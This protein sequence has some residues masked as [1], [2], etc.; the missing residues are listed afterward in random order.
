M[1][2]LHFGRFGGHWNTTALYGVMVL[3]V[4]LGIGPFVLMVTGLLM[5]WN[6]SL[7]KK[8]RR[9]RARGTAPGAGL[10]GDVMSGPHPSRLPGR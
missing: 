7:V 10:A 1:Y 6:R 3:Y 5:Y 2:P 4:I 8:W 9:M